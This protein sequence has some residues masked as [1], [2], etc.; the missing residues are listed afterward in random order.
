MQKYGGSSVSTAA[1]MRAVAEMITQVRSRD[2]HVVVVV[3]AMGDSTD[4]LLELARQVGPALSPRELD[5]LLSTGETV[6]AALL[7]LAI[8]SLGVDAVSLS[9]SQCGIITNDVYSNAR[10]LEVRPDRIK[11]ELARGAVVVVPGF[12]GVTKHQETTTLGRGGSDTS[13]VAI[14][15]ALGA[16]SCEIY[17]DVNGVYSADPR[18]VSEAIAL[19]DL[20]ATEMEELA[21]HGAQVVKAEAVEFART[22]G[23]A[24][25]VRSAFAQ[26]QGTFIPPE[27]S[28]SVYRPHRP[29]VA[30]VTGRKDLVRI[31][32]HRPTLTSPQMDEIFASLS[33]YD[34]IFG[35]LNG[36]D[37]TSE[38]FI[39][40]LEIPDPDAFAAELAPRFNGAVKLTGDLGAV[41][42][43]GFGLGSRPAALLEALRV[44]EEENVPL[45]KSFTG[46]ES[47]TFVIPRPLVDA[48][49]K[50]LHRV[51]VENHEPALQ[52]NSLPLMWKTRGLN[53]VDTFELLES[54]V[55]VYCRDFPTV[56]TKGIG[57][58][59]FDERGQEFLDF[60]SGAGTLNYGHNNPRMKRRLIEYLENDSITHS[61]DMATTVKREFLERFNSVILAPR[62]LEYKIQFCGPTG[63]N[64]VEAA[65]KLA[66]K[67]TGRQTV[68]FF[69]NAYHGLSLGSLA[70]TGNASKRA[71]AGVTLHYAMPMPYD[72]DL[73]PNVNTL[74]YFEAFLENSGSGMELPAAVIVETIQAEGGVKVASYEWLRRL[75]DLARRHG[76]VF[77]ID[78]IQVGCGRTGSFFSF[79]DAGL[80]PDMVCLSK[81]ISG[82]GLPMALLLIRPE[83]D[84]WE[85][86][87]H[88]GTFRGNN[89]AF[90]TASEALAYWE[91][92]AFA[93]LILKKSELLTR[94]MKEIVER[95]PEARGWVRGRGLI[96]GLGFD[97]EGL[98]QEVAR[99]AFER[100]LIIETSGAQSQ[101]V[102]LLPPLTIDEEDLRDGI[103]RL[104]DSLTIALGRTAMTRVAVSGEEMRA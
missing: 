62:K 86:G 25:L 95:H 103:D 63:T 71:G 100:G 43:V 61:L 46:R 41:S 28:Q 48:S 74:D 29:E 96:Q 26:G 11:K 35:G 52:L 99:A 78:D 56:F 69:M 81:A 1:K 94:L 14:A 18:V 10:I 31:R 57:C 89:L 4:N 93:D 70:V 97:V 83:L 40:N 13:A 5:R 67:A 58:R 65:L 23:V 92:E 42:L 60:F 30:A 38:L 80:R 45:I 12:Q 84:V 39:S 90:V 98:A 55:R 2:Q 53:I 66:R 50:R 15:A 21:W 72:G 73:G 34:L 76:I 91:D 27:S 82:F 51:F 79:E 47:L 68:V 16:E 8:Q 36:A 104:I 32:L 59:L 37:E 17:T 87:E 20:G 102:K 6:S 19:S 7:S 64:A 3:S 54:E 22:N 49:V 77:I 9:A 88:T 33:K 101:V 44:L 75:E 24:V 85:P